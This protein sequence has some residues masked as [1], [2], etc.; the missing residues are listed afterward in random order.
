MK[1]LGIGDNVVDKYVHL[2]MMYP[3]GNALNFSVFAKRA[4]VDAAFI[5]VFGD[6]NEGRHVEH[7]LRELDIDISRCRY[8]SGENGCARV[9]LEEG[10]RVF[11]DSNE[12]GVTRLHPLELSEED[13]AY[14]RGF[15]LIHTG[16][17]SHTG[18]LLPELEALEIPLSFDFSDDFTDTQVEQYITHANFAFFSCSHMT[19]EE[20]QNYIRSKRKK[21]DKYWLLHAVETDLLHMMEQ[22]FISKCLNPLTQWIQWGQ[23]TRILLPFY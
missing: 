16:L 1:V 8:H 23:G 12:G 20:T 9:T 5:G 14:L 2:R 4:G 19:D 17:Y 10:D 11:L 13:K 15:D 3:G 6:D 18:H 22:G 21:K 7:I